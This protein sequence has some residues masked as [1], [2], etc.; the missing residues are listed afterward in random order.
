MH[1]LVFH[2]EEVHDVLR[3]WDGPQDGGVLLRE[4]S[5]STLPPDLHS[6]FNS[7]SLQFTT[8]F[9]TS[10]QGFALQFSVSTATSCNDPGIPTNGTR[11]GD[12]REPGDNV[13]F[14]CDPGYL[15]QGATK[16]TCTEI[17]NR[18]FWQPDPPTC[19]APCGGNL[20]GPSGLILSPEYPEP[21]PHGR[22]CDWTVTVTPDHII[23]LTFNHLEPSYDFLHVYD[24]PDSLS[25]LLGSFYGTDV[26]D[27]IESSSNTLFL[28]FRSD[29]SLSSNGFVLQYTGMSS[30]CGGRNKSL[31]FLFSRLLFLYCE[32]IWS[33]G[34]S[35]PYCNRALTVV[36]ITPS[37]SYRF[38]VAELK[39]NHNRTLPTDGCRW[40]AAVREKTN[41]LLTD[42]QPRLI[43]LRENP[44]ESCFEPGLVRNGTRVG[45]ELK[46]GATVAYYCDNGYTLEG[47]ATLT[48]IMGGDGK[49][50]WN[51]PKPVCIAL[52]GGQYSGLEGVVLSPGYPGNYSSG[53]TCLYSVIV[54]KDYVVFSQF[55]FF[56]TALNDVVEVYD[57]PTQHARVLSSLSGAHTVFWNP[58]RKVSSHVSLLHNTLEC[59][60]THPPRGEAMVTDV[61][62]WCDTGLRVYEQHCRIMW[63]LEQAAGESLP[64]ATS[65]QIL[66]RFSSKGQSSSRAVPRTSATQCSSVPEPRHGRRTGNNFAVGAVVSFECNAGYVLE[67]PS[68][69][70][71]L[72]VP[73]ALAQWNGSM[74]SCI[75][76]C[77][78]NLTQRI[79][80]IL[81]PG[82]PEPYLNSLSCVWKITVPEGMGI[83]IQVISFVTEQNWDSLEVF[84]GGDNTDT[85]LGSFSGTTVPA[86]LNSTSN[87]LYLH[88]FSDISVSA[89]GFRLEYKTVSL[90]SCPEPVV[91]MNGFKVGERLQM[92]SVM[93]FQ[94]DP[95]YTLQG[96]SHIS[97]M[98]GPVRRWNYPPPL[99]IA[100]C[101]GI[102]EEMEGTILSPGFPG[103]Y[104][105]NS[106]CTWR[107]Y[108]PVGYGA[109]VQ[110][111]NFST[112][113]NHDFLEI[114]NGPFDTSTVIGRF[115]GQDLPPSLLTTSHETTI[116]FH[117][118][119]SQN[120]PGFR[121]DY[122][123]YELQECPDPEPFRNGVVV[124]AG[125]N[126]GQ[127][128]SFECYPGYQL[129]GHSILTCQHG[130][131]RNWD[132]PF[133]RCE[134]PCG[135]NITSDN[136]TI[137][138][139]GYPEDYPTSADCSWLITVAR[140]LG[141]HL[142]FTLLQVHGPQD[143]ITVWIHSFEVKLEVQCNQN[144]REKL[145]QDSLASLQDG[146]QET[147]RKL[148]VF[149]EGEPNN[150]PSSTSNQVLIRFRSNSEKAYRLQ[151]CLPPPIIPNA[152]ILMASKEFKIGLFDLS[153]T[154]HV[155]KTSV[156]QPMGVMNVNHAVW[157]FLNY[158]AMQRRHA[159]SPFASFLLPF[160]FY[161]H[162]QPLSETV[163][164]HGLHQVVS[165][166]TAGR[167]R[168]CSCCS[169]LLRNPMFSVIFQKMTCIRKTIDKAVMNISSV[170]FLF[171][172][173]ILCLPGYHLNGNSIQTCR[174][175]T[176]LEFE[177]P[178][179]SCDSANMYL[180]NLHAGVPSLK[181]CN[182]S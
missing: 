81:S 60:M 112:E 62:V 15:L 40:H 17:N 36:L 154:E 148:G 14:Q 2:T 92:N 30:P 138:S 117:S 179:P 76:P 107:I 151:F 45:T 129:M 116:Y 181:L 19:S 114:R 88:F 79:G 46:L 93:S 106:D 49:P 57:G 42:S 8:D 153:G 122:Q 75:V 94:C 157:R 166:A 53:R 160:F 56:H 174:L 168:C 97:C 110:F 145:H 175:G 139:P 100:Q 1:F 125:Y 41:Q 11:I 12:S 85:M 64:L 96:V 80:T 67:G 7:V 167:A 169:E 23:S 118:D 4:L 18:F 158:T 99:C 31:P 71:C 124:G 108:L 5:G 171:P 177:G 127:S 65:N 180:H 77:G 29:A 163:R 26:P 27:R 90:T 137:F 74:P 52:C 58:D 48:C 63:P 165:E 170:H 146:P 44:R 109:H 102:R 70:E 147:A 105:S 66:I 178:P 84:D 22:E 142:N 6:T 82:Y 134:V 104:P 83:Q 156:G 25:P 176:H 98:P 119:H 21:Y 91:P 143:F 121:F 24:G 131:T 72:T 38:R 149:T 54:P 152:E 150:P 47:D 43:G 155:C 135:G 87:Q 9:F 28:A 103:N 140:G 89:A 39:V 144:S 86:L 130:T 61:V 20:T 132:H 3:I 111:L 16:I 126:V 13:L 69:I 73:N 123:A 55:A 35:V 173:V 59:C 10:K 172:Q 182:S 115:S 164:G 162:C 141:I 32:R 78:G 33:Y 68:A 51:K 133:P 95:G 113:A 120:K 136:G 159:E 34:S 37:C 161:R 50:G 128:I 101:G